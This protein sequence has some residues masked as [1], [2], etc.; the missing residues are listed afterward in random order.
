MSD[1]NAFLP[2]ADDRPLTVER[3]FGEERASHSKV[4]MSELIFAMAK[5]RGQFPPIPRNRTVKVRT[6]T[7]GSY[8]FK[9]ATFDAILGAITPVLSAHGLVVMQDTEYMDGK[10]ALT[11]TVAHGSGETV[12]LGRVEGALSPEMS[13]Q[14]LGSLLTY[15]QRYS[16][17]IALCLGTEDDDDGNLASGNDASVTRD[18]PPRTMA[19]NPTIVTKI[20]SCAT[21]QELQDYW[22]VLSTE[23]RAAHSS[24]KDAR[25][26]VLAKGE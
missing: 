3:V 9:Y 15:L 7:G 21:M 5:A 16:I 25:K 8:E 20:N 11:T 23:E 19:L 10:V 12:S 2:Q 6:K 22:S 13:P 14:E 26:H 1:E 24:V 17:R 18:D 4:S